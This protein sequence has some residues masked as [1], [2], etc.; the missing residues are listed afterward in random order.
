LRLLG[1]VV[2][3]LV[4]QALLGVA[5]AFQGAIE[6]F[7]LIDLR[8]LRHVGL[9]AGL[10]EALLGR[11]LLLLDGRLRRRVLVPLRLVLRLGR[12]LLVGP[13]PFL[14]LQTDRRLVLVGGGAVLGEEPGGDDGHDEQAGND[15]TNHGLSPSF[16]SFSGGWLN[17][18]SSSVTSF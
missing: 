7:L 1:A 12:R 4:G 10:L 11:R 2:R 13:G 5:R 16:S 15:A 6:D 17:S 3:L 18:S 14:L 8:L 9:L